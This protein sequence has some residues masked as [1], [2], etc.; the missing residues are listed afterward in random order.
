MFSIYLVIYLLFIFLPA[1]ERAPP[2]KSKLPE[3]IFDLFI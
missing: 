1:S 2:W 3:Q